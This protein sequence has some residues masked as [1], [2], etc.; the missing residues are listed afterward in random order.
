[1]T[2]RRV[3]AFAA[4]TELLSA[5]LAWRGRGHVR[6]A[7]EPR[8]EREAMTGASV[9]TAVEIGL[10]LSLAG[11]VL[12]ALARRQGWSAKPWTRGTRRVR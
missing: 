12:F 8:L 3:L 1:M 9:L 7:H 4:S 10:I 6:R 5:G 11:G 2:R